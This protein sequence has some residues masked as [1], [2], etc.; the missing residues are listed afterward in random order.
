MLTMFDAVTVGNIPADAQYVA[1]YIDGYNNYP[2]GKARFPHATILTITV[3]G[4]VADCCD[5]ES[6]AMTPAGAVQWV[7]DRLAAGA[8]RPCVYAD[9]STWDGDLWAPLE[10][11]GDKIR[12]WVAAY[13]GTGVNIPAGYDAHQ[14]STGNLDTS[15]CLDNFFAAKP[16][17]PPVP[18]GNARF[19]GT[20]DL[21]TG[22]VVH[23]H[24]L[25]GEGVHFGPHDQ[26][27][28]VDV[29]INAHTGHWRG[30]P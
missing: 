1:L 2:A 12:R 30:R 6:G 3:A 18:R 11:Y 20:F 27:L 29:Q 21:H 25:P 16:S 17:P 22:K 9:A 4:A 7:A 5:C 13:P 14:Y 10:H 15:V 24:G 8:W 26:W 19:A 28:D 23:I